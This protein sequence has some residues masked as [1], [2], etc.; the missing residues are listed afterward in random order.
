MKKCTIGGQAVMEG[1]MMKSPEGYGLAVRKE[2][3]TIVREYH[4]NKKVRAKGSFATWPVVRGVAIFIDALVTGVRLT[5]R[6]AELLGEDITEEPSRFEK[7]LAE[8]LGKSVFDIAMVIAVVLAIG[9]SVG[10][11]VILPSFLASLFPLKGLLYSL[12][13]GLVRLVIFLGY[14]LAISR[15]KAIRRVFAYHGA[16]H[17]TIA[18]YE[19]DEDLTPENA[20]KYTRLHPR[21]GTNFMF[22]VMAVAILFFACVPSL[23]MLGV[24]ATRGLSMLYRIGTRLLFIPVVAGLSYEV[25]RAAAKGDNLFA[26]IVRAPGLALQRLTTV[27]PDES[28]VEVAIVAFQLAL[29]PPAEDSSQIPDSSDQTEE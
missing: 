12:A 7:W 28:M 15:L 1:V 16:E 20:M 25:L 11:F 14:L 2:D 6:S 19:N 3:G 9:L 4:K 10:L 18:C 13:E 26:R 29:D 27:E 23:E 21:C 8:K 22:L 24:E 5:M 17:K